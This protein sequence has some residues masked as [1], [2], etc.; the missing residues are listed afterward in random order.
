MLNFIEYNKKNK[1]LSGIYC[2]TN[3]IDDRIYIGSTNCFYKRF[4]EHSRDFC[5]NNH[6]NQHLQNFVNKYGIDSIKYNIL[7]IADFN[8]LIVKEQY[9]LDN[10]INF[11]KDFNICKIAGTPPNHNRQFTEEDIK[12]IAELYNSGKSCCQISEILFN[13]RNQRSKIAKITKGENYSEYKDLFNYRKYNQTGRKFSQE[14]KDKI[15][16]ANK[17]NP[18]IGG[19]GLLRKGRGKLDKEIVLYIRNNPD[20]ISQSKLALKFDIS[21]SLVKD[22]QKLRTYNKF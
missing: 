6:G 14:T 3:T 16:K 18:N 20:K 2:I 22:I 17:G 7:E 5:K 15:S 9:Y 4:Y 12:Y 13:H 11:N 10:F 21:K 1:Y 8:N 19:K